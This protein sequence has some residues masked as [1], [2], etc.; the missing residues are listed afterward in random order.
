VHSQT[1]TSFLSYNDQTLLTN[2]FHEYRRI[3]FPLTFKEHLKMPV[4]ETLTLEKFM[5]ATANMYMGLIYYLKSI[6]EVS[7]LPVNAKT[8]LIKCNLNQITRVHSTFIMKVVTP[9]LDTDSPVFLQIFPE[10]LYKDMRDTST[11]LIPFV[12]DPILIKLFIIVL[13]L[14][15]HMSVR[16]EE[17]LMINEDGNSSRNIFYVQNIYVELL[18]RYLLSRVSNYRQSVKLFSSLITRTLY[19][20]LVEVKIGNFIRSVLPNQNQ[21]LEPIIN[22]MWSLNINNYT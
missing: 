14:S 18:W 19:S 4:D 8:F 13:M 10:D 20:Q 2:I 21:Q 6:P 11:D 3:C 9:D 17:N 1:Y 16:Y 12:N 5:N 22:S 7:L 15:T